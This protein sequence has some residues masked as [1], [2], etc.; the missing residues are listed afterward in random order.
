MVIVADVR[1][2]Y[3]MPQV[4][5]AKTY[6]SIIDLS[7]G[8]KRTN[9]EVFPFLLCSPLLA[10]EDNFGLHYDVIGYRDALSLAIHVDDA[11]KKKRNCVDSLIWNHNL[12]MIKNLEHV[13]SMV[14]S[15]F[16]DPHP[17][18]RWSAVNVLGQLATDLAKSSSS[19]S[20]CHG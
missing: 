4:F 2:V 5:L 6:I 9:K 12:V 15:S 11:R 18:M 3:I 10:I 17:C 7:N 13:V 16:Q 14:L 19:S 8:T 20:N 1:Q